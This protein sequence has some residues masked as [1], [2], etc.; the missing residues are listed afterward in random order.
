MQSK[1]KQP[2]WTPKIRIETKSVYSLKLAKYT[3]S[4]KC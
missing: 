2:N 3:R 4:R 1:I